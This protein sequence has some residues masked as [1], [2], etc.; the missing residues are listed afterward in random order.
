MDEITYFMHENTGGGLPRRRE[1]ADARPVGGVE[2]D[3]QRLSH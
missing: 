1:L 3:G 2:G